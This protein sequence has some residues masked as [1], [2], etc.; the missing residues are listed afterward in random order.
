MKDI[1]LAVATQNTAIAQDYQEALNR[2]RQ[3]YNKDSRTEDCPIY[4]SR[5]LPVNAHSNASCPFKAEMCVKDVQALWLDTGL[6]NSHDHYG[7]NTR[8]EDRV[9]WRQVA[10]CAPVNTEGFS[11]RS[12]WKYDQNME[13][14]LLQPGAEMVQ[15]FYG[16]DNGPGYPNM[17]YQYPANYTE[18]TKGQLFQGPAEDYRLGYVADYEHSYR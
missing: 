15:L 11:Q 10:H 5:S 18:M 12:T 16:I 2:A 14:I 6:L 4:V 1:A 13:Q 3:C 9:A 17:T 8:T 7:I